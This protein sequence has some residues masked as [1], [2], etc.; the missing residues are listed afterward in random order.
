M[1][2]IGDTRP[3][4]ESSVSHENVRWRGLAA[5]GEGGILVSLGLVSVHAGDT[6]EPY[7]SYGLYVWTGELVAIGEAHIGSPVN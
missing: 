7:E 6:G 2:D 3:F 4:T 1:V 5:K